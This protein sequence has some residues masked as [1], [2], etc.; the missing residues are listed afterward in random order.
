M[1]G[2]RYFSNN[3]V[4]LHVT[5]QGCNVHYITYITGVWMN[6]QIMIF[7]AILAV[8]PEVTLRVTKI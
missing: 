6:T 1:I 4:S 2:Y 8:L 3:T 7:F 5:P